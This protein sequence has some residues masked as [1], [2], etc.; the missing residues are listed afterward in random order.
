MSP[1]KVSRMFR[2][3]AFS[4]VIIAAL[5]LALCAALFVFQRALIYF[6]QPSAIATPASLL[7]LTVEDAQ[8]QVS[9][10]PHDGPNALIYFGGNAE[11]V[12]RNLAD[13]SQAFP[14]HAL[15]LMHY[16]GYGGS[17]GS[18]SEEAI[19]HDALTL[20]DT[21]YNRHPNIA[22]VG[23]SLGSGVAVRLASQRPASRLILITPYNSLESLA[24]QRFP[25]FP[26]KWL[27]QDRYESWRYAAH[28]TVPTLLIAAGH[29]DV[30]P[31]SSTQQLYTHF[32]PGVATLKVIP[33]AG[34]NSLSDSPEYLKLLGDGL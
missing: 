8:V 21:V 25:L 10:R 6:P 12:S 17:T 11:D 23:R 33:D 20:F 27:L 29:D 5:Y 22:V 14:E 30:I 9:V 15:Y 19:A 3:L 4:I 18:P 28:I 1:T 26:V 34:H 32:A 13:F 7:T 31:R 16:R 24:K 2:T